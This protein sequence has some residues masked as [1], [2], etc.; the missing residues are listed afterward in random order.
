MPKFE[1]KRVFPF[2]GF[3]AKKMEY[4][5]VVTVNLTGNPEM[6]LENHKKIMN[7]EE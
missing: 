1:K 3:N 5:K 6:S 2:Q 4:S 7:H